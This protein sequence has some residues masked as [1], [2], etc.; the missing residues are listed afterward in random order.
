MGGLDSQEPAEPQSL[1]V[2]LKAAGVDRAQ[3]LGGLTRR[4]LVRRA[5]VAI[6]VVAV[7]A[8]A[9]VELP[10]LH[11]VRARLAGAH[12]GWIVASAVMEALSIA[13]FALALQRAF[14]DQLAPRGAIALGATSQGVN[15]V[16]PAGG[17]AG[18]AFAAV[19]FADAGFPVASTVGRLIALF[20]ITSVMTNLVLI[21][22]GGG[23]SAF[24]ILTA[25]ASLGATVIPGVLAMAL[26]VAFTVALRPAR[27]ARSTAAPPTRALSRA[28]FLREAIGL[29]GALVSDR[30]PWLAVG[31]LGYVI[32]DLLALATALAALGG[33]GLGAGT[34]ILGYTLGQIGSVIPLPGATEGGLAGALALY[35]ASLSLAVPAVL[36]YRTVAIAVPLLLA[37]LGALELRHGLDV[38]GASESTT[39]PATT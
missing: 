27:R 16:V 26:L 31:A 25:H 3:V 8:L 1:D 14:K 4:Q 7:V 33:G 36:V 32:F 12:P 24:G 39:W 6:G 9:I 28:R 18:F 23:G 34:V 10:A 21:V 29:S 2:Q 13:C 11:V 22:V 37:A 35:G 15:A 17:T 20:L 30:D 19:I 5:A 38:T